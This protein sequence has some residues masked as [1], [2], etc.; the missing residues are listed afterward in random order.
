MGPQ[1]RRAYR[2]LAVYDVLV[3]IPSYVLLLRTLILRATGSKRLAVLPLIA[4][5]ADLV[6][7]STQAYLTVNPLLI[8]RLASIAS[9]C[10]QLKFALI[11]FSFL[12]WP[13]SASFYLR[14]RLLPWREEGT[15]GSVHADASGEAVWGEEDGACVALAH[16]STEASQKP[17]VRLEVR[18]RE[19]YVYERAV[20]SAEVDAAS[21]VAGVK[22]EKITEW[23]EVREGVR[24]ALELSFSR[25]ATLPRISSKD[26]LRQ[27]LFRLTTYTRPTWC[28]VC[29]QLLVGI[30]HQGFRCEACGLDCHRDCQ[31]K[32][33]AV[34]ECSRALV[35]KTPDETLLDEEDEEDWEEFGGRSSGGGS[36]ATTA[37]PPPPPPLPPSPPSP[38]IGEL[39]LRLT[40]LATKFGDHYVR[41]HV[42]PSREA[43]WL[44]EPSRGPGYF[45]PLRTHT[46]YESAEPR[47]D[48]TWVFPI[49]TFSSEVRLE[50]VDAARD[51]VVGTLRFGVLDLEQEE[52]D[53][54]ATD[55]AAYLDK[56]CRAYVVGGDVLADAFFGS[57]E[58]KC[59]FSRFYFEDREN[60][61]FRDRHGAP[62]AVAKFAAAK[63]NLKVAVDDLWFS[64][65]PR[66]ASPEPLPETFSMELARRHVE[67][68]RQVIRWINETY[69]A[70]ER[71]MRWTD[72][73]ITAPL[74]AAF[75]AT[76]VWLDAEHVGVVPLALLVAFFLATA[77]NR[78]LGHPRK[79]YFEHAARLAEANHLGHPGPYRPLGRLRVAVCAGRGLG[80]AYETAPD[81]YVVVSFAP[82][83]ASSWA[84]AQQQQQHKASGAA[85]AAAA[86]EEEEEEEEEDEEDVF[87]SNS[88]LHHHHGRCEDDDDNNNNNS[89]RERQKQQRREETTT[90][91]EE[92]SGSKNEEH[93]LGYT[94]TCR[95]K[96]PRWHGALGVSLEHRRRRR[97]PSALISRLVGSL[98]VYGAAVVEPWERRG[99]GETAQ[100]LVDRSLVYPVLRPAEGGELLPWSKSGGMLKFRVVR[101]HPLDRL[102][103]KQLGAVSVAVASLVDPDG[104]RRGG[105]Q[106]E[107]RGWHDLDD[108]DLDDGDEN[109]EK[110]DP[111]EN[112]DDDD[113][114]SEAPPPGLNLRL[115]L[116]LAKPRS[117]PTLEDMETSR[118]VEAMANA[119]LDSPQN[120]PDRDAKNYRTNKNRL[121]NPLSTVVSVHANATYAQNV[122]GW[123][124]DILESL[125]NA[126]SWTHPWKTAWLFGATLFATLLFAR[127]PTRW[128]ALA[129]GFYEFTYRL[130]PCFKGSPMTARVLNLLQS[131]PND[132]DL[133]RCY[134]HRAATFARK[135]IE[136]ERR[137]R[138][139]AKLH[140]IWQPA[141][142]GPVAVREKNNI[143]QKYSPVFF[144]PSHLVVHGRRLLWWHSEKDI[145]SGRP[146]KGQ[147]LLMGHSGLTDP[148]PTDISAAGP[149]RADSLL[150]GFY[151]LFQ[152][153]RFACRP[154]WCRRC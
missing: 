111:V 123:S 41:T 135:K 33:H 94:G 141:W 22:K 26:V 114:E 110:N 125:K 113:D 34:R 45:G 101:E 137:R 98:N 71:V 11:V 134:E 48:A 84:V 154:R 23:A 69:E 109:E 7:T 47:F 87:F 77:R 148:S 133:R 142:Q 140:A 43:P 63:S 72:P 38:G 149:L 89:R 39:E 14:V 8:P 67:R 54:V 17:C 106:K 82:A 62:T 3:C 50:L 74:F 24:V 122:L 105:P 147:L 152:R 19:M 78:L 85:A 65:S 29:E 91:V 120:S 99:F 13:L 18:S 86:Q 68:A 127:I 31:L 79:T 46:V 53:R 150:A 75:V 119:K 115:Q 144:D 146:P 76:C 112:D 95:S 35:S 10:V 108:L 40:S 90:T 6:E 37:P 44:S 117:T 130:V 145:D 60:C 30:R 73:L 4:A 57:V 61:C 32:A 132:D 52:A 80:A 151:H 92:E 129:I 9:F 96:S 128:L 138:R 107:R 139:R 12:E 55:A 124:L 28:A 64:S 56:A 102:L 20:G 97:D 21:L 27:H 81:V 100:P 83:V 104:D 93:V 126:F 121:H 88:S 15:T 118:A 131:V 51:L 16:L 42:A 153:P 70:Y 66:L 5:F 116:I 49:S 58:T 136:N 2:A 1:G 59:I 103:D 36:R 143:Q 25:G